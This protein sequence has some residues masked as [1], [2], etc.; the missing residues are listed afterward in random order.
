MEAAFLDSCV[1]Y[2]AALRDFLMRLAVDTY[3]PKWTDE[4][5]EEWIRNVL[6]DRPDLDRKQLERTRELMNRR[7]GDC[8]VTGYEHLIPNLTLPDPDDRH[9]LAAAVTGRATVI[10][11]FNL[12][13][14]PN[15]ILASLGIRAMHPDDFASALYDQEPEAFLNAVREHRRALVNPAKTA[16]EYLSTLHGAGLNKTVARLRRH[17]DEI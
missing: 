8:L 15:H 6:E 14:F 1:L 12:R 16:D 5:H 17:V 7:G 3:V 9:I 11:T 2:P 10:V 4:V 13:H